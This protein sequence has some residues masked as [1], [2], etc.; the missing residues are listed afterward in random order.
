MNFYDKIKKIVNANNR[1]VTTKEII[2]LAYIT[3]IF[4]N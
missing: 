1:Y 4:D 3:D 2:A